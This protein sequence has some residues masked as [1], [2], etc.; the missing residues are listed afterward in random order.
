MMRPPLS[1]ASPIEKPVKRLRVLMIREEIVPERLAGATAV[2]LD[3][4]LA[5][6]T[7]LTI[8][9]N[10]AGRVFRAVPAV[11][12]GLEHGQERRR[13]LVPAVEGLA[14]RVP[15]QLVAGLRELVYDAVH[16]SASSSIGSA[17]ILAASR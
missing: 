10:G 16:A 17:A 3:V 14:H 12:E 7:L 2:V 9:E 6:T 8:L 1:T 11:G 15:G 5:T 13:G 4:F